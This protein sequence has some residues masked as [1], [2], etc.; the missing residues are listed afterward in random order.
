MI[1]R[2][3]ISFTAGA[4]FSCTLSCSSDDN[5]RNDDYKPKRHNLLIYRSGYNSDKIF[6]PFQALELTKLEFDQRLETE[7]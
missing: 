1:K 7:Q 6:A 4:R 2:D 5:T 3:F